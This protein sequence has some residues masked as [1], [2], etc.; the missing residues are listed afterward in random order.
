MAEPALLPTKPRLSLRCPNRPRRLRLALAVQQ[1]PPCTVEE[2][3]AITEAF[4]HAAKYLEKA[5]FDGIQL[6]GAHGFLLAQFLSPK[7]N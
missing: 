6:H 2:I 1:A 7:T 4:A 3:A 5:G